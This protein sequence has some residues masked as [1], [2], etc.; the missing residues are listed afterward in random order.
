MASETN[1]YSISVVIPAY[2]AGKHIARAI[3]SVLAQT[4]PPC[5]IIVVDD[6]STDDTAQVVASYRPKVTYIYQDNA[7]ASVARNTGI[8]AAAGQ[9]IA[10]LD[11]DDEWL[12]DKL[13]LQIE[14]L[15][16]NP[17]LVWTTGNYINCVCS[18]N[19]QAPHFDP[20]KA[21]KLISGREYWDNYFHALLNNLGGWTGTML[22]RRD[23]LIECGLFVPGRQRGED[24]GMWWRIAYRK[25]KIGV[26]ARMPR[27]HW[28]LNEI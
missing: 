12:A 8:Q 15:K 2:N 22:I 4:Q 1:E 10:F 7:G 27:T 18:K 21:D 13:K 16:R 14:H 28:I 20:V 9:W 6:G 26:I 3:D 17:D 25:P 24:I 11:A 5:E 23:I 19:R